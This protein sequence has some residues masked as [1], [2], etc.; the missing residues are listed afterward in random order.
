V[1]EP[2]KVDLQELA[3]GADAVRGHADLLAAGHS[4]ATSVMDAARS[5]LVGRSADAVVARMDR[6]QATTAELHRALAS[7]GDALRS[8]A[9]AYDRTEGDNRDMIASLNP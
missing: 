5:G 2:I 9:A 8:A 4:S 3:Y 7:Q 6:W 1:P